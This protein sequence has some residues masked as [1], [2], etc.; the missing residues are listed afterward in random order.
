MSDTAA[1]EPIDFSEAWGGGGEPATPVEA[2]PAQ[3]APTE[4]AAPDG[5]LQATDT[6]VKISGVD[7]TTGDLEQLLSELSDLQDQAKSWE[8]LQGERQKLGEQSAALR[9]A[10]AIQQM[11]TQNPEAKEA[12]RPFLEAK[13]G[14]TRDP[15]TGQFAKRIGIEDPRIT[16]DLIQRFE[17]DHKFVEQ[18][19]EAHGDEAIDKTWEGVKAQYPGL[20][21][22]AF[23]NRITDLVI[24]YERATSRKATPLDL[25]HIA[26]TELAAS[27]KLYEY[28]RQK[29]LEEMKKLPEGARVITGKGRTEPEEKPVDIGAY[30]HRDFEQELVQ[31]GAVG[32]R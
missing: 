22:E 3:A 4:G 21:D 11:L 19:R 26:S 31:S 25:I 13:E 5:A 12:L 9:E 28:G 16:S 8:G 14:T 18:I 29:A 20:V 15:E 2:A 23:E 1:A 32:K 24:A 7:F 30:T 17:D 10:I 27:G 6:T